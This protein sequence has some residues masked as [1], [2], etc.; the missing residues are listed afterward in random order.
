MG[1]DFAVAGR[2]MGTGWL[3]TALGAELSPRPF[4]RA[5]RHR[6]HAVGQD[7]IFCPYPAAGSV[8]TGTISI[9]GPEHALTASA[10]AKVASTW[11]TL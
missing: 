3:K 5:W 7:G 6:K 2:G 10:K 9:V 11:P 4:E 8:F 1:R